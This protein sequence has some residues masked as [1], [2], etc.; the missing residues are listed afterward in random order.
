MPHPSPLVPDR[1]RAPRSALSVLAVAAVLLGSPPWS[2]DP[3]RAA[4]EDRPVFEEVAS[5]DITVDIDLTDATWQA[6]TMPTV[7]DET[8]AVSFAPG[9][10]YAPDG[11]VLVYRDGSD[12]PTRLRGGDAAP[13]DGTTEVAPVAYGGG[14][15]DFL[16]IEL[17]TGDEASD[18]AGEPFVLP[19]GDW[20]LT[21]WSLDLPAGLPGAYPFSEATTEDGEPV[22][23]DPD[24]PTLLVATYGRVEVVPGE[25][26]G[27]EHPIAADGEAAFTMAGPFHVTPTDVE[28]PREASVVAVTI[29]AA[30]GTDGTDGTDGALTGRS[31]T[32]DD[33]GGDTGDGGG[34]A[35]RSAPSGPAAPDPA[36][37][38]RD[39]DGLTDEQEAFFGSDPDDGDTDDDGLPDGTETAIASSPT[40]VDSDGDCVDDGTEVTRG[41]NPILQVTDPAAGRDGLLGCTVG[42]L[43]PDPATA[44]SDGDGLTDEQEARVGTDPAAADS[45]DDG[46]TDGAEFGVGTSPFDPDSDGDCVFDGRELAAGFNPLNPFTFIPNPDSQT[47]GCG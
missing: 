4:Q 39:G 40:R 16:A 27:L 23:L 17:T 18:P 33:D 8:A 46:L 22:D 19:A 47:L 29:T 43:P 7:D 24:L 14:E 5:Q 11:V 34:A 42:T 6:T 31:G 44:D 20:T 13:L 9:F 3:A 30:D 45:D 26:A 32:D 41:T 1:R 10:L 21:L 28:D 2:P 38:D 36:T 15:T 12:R 37:A 35:P 25:G